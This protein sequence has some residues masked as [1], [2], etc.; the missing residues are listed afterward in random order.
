MNKYTN[1]N[2]YKSPHDFSKQEQLYSF[3]TWLKFWEWGK[4][5]KQTIK[6]NYVSIGTCSKLLFNFTEIFNFS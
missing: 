3:I 5:V 4:M 6:W 1:S 2:N